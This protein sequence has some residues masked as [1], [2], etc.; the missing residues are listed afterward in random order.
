MPFVKKTEIAK[1]LELLLSIRD[2]SEQEEIRRLSDRARATL[3]RKT[4]ESLVPPHD[5]SHGLPANQAQAKRAPGRKATRIFYACDI[6]GSES[7]FQKFMNSARFYGVDVLILAGDLTGKGIVP[8]V[9]QRD[10]SYGIDFLGERHRIKARKKLA[11]LRARVRDS[12][13]Y[14][15]FTT[16]SEVSEL[17]NDQNRLDRKFAELTAE[18]LRR[19][20]AAADEKLKNLGIECYVSPGNDDSRDIDVL[21]EGSRSIVNPDERVVKIADK[22]EML[23]LGF[24]NPS[25]WNLPRDTTEEDLARRISALSS[26]MSDFSTAI[27]NLHCPPYGTGLDMGPLIEPRPVKSLATRLPRSK[28]IGSAPIGSVAVKNAIEKYQPLMS[29]HGHVHESRGSCRIGRT[30]C[31]NPGSEYFEGL[32]LG[33]LLDID[34]KNNVNY[35]F[36][37]G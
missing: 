18:T 9:E 5:I 3:L 34:T 4:E 24:S 17:R 14:P 11:E 21:I 20:M 26:S 28:S 35:V 22:F 15:F 1:I 36:T 13:F 30:I 29:L 16:I 27:F 2:I 10:G 12:G 23:T 7:C 33:L 6:H 37:S 31:F 25:P 32:L 8:F 19:W